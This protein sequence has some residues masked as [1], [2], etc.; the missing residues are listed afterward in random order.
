MK[1]F[2]FHLAFP[3]HDD[4]AAGKHFVLINLLV[5]WERPDG[6]GLSVSIPIARLYRRDRLDGRV[7]QLKYS[8]VECLC[9]RRLS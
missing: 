3:I 4:V 6:T 2:L 1:D 9:C 5:C 7:G 8:T